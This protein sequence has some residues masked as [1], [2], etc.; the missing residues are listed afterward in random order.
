MPVNDLL[1][2][3]WA[4]G[5]FARRAGKVTLIGPSARLELAF[6]EVSR[7]GGIGGDSVTDG[8]ACIVSQVSKA[9]G[10]TSCTLFGLLVLF[11]CALEVMRHKFCTSSAKFERTQRAEMIAA[12]GCGD[13]GLGSREYAVTGA[14]LKQ[15]EVLDL[16]PSALFS[17]AEEVRSVVPTEARTVDHRA[18]AS[19]SV[20]KKKRAARLSSWWR[21]FTAEIHSRWIDIKLD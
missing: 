17:T 14:A 13:A 12:Q 16:K 6:V 20:Q 10:N 19:E 3:S 8:G 5:K 4:S 1:Q 18:L 21:A 9:M 11:R 2:P 7:G 15:T